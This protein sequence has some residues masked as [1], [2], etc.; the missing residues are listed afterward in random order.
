M[1]SLLVSLFL[2][3]VLPGPVEGASPPAADQAAIQRAAVELGDRSFAVRQRASQFLWRQGREAESALQQVARNGTGEAR[4]R[5]EQLLRD[6]R[7]GVVPAVPSHVIDLIRTYSYGRPAERQLAF[8][9]LL[10]NDH[11]VQVESLIRQEADPEV[12]QA[13][14]VRLCEAQSSA[15]RLAEVGDLTDLVDRVAGDQD[16]AWRRLTIARLLSTTTMIEQL[17]ERDQLAVLGDLVSRER[18]ADL[19]QQMLMNVFQNSGAVAA[20]IAKDEFDFLLSL[21]AAEPDEAA[22]DALLIQ[23]LTPANVATEVVQRGKLDVVL[24]FLRA[25][26]SSTARSQI[27]QQMLSTT[28]VVS[29]I[30]EDAGL[31]GVVALARD[32]QDPTTRGELLGRL[33][34][35]MQVRTHLTR[36]GQWKR[37]IQVAADEP[38]PAARHAYLD[39]LLRY[40]VFYSLKPDDGLR[41]LWLVVRNDED[42]AWR[43]V[44]AARLLASHQVEH[45]L[46]DE[47][48]IQWLLSQLRDDGAP[49][50]RSQLLDAAIRT[51][52]LQRMLL[53]RGLFAELFALARREPETT[54]VDLVMRLLST[55]N[56]AEQLKASNEVDLMLDMVDE[57][58][59]PSARREYLAGLFRNHWAMEAL[60][61]NGHYERLF[62]LARQETNEVDRAILFAEFLRTNPV[63][64]QIEERDQ[65]DT[66]IQYAEVQTD[67]NARHEYLKRLFTNTH[68]LT[69]L[70]DKDK[71]DALHR[72][73][74]TEADPQRRSELLASFFSMPN[75]LQ[76]MIDRKRADEVLEFAAGI[77]DEN[78][79]RQFLQ[80]LL[81]NRKAVEA[82]VAE[83]KFGALLELARS[84]PH[85]SYRASQIG[86][87]LRAP[88]V[89]EHLANGGNLGQL[90]EVVR[91]E[92]HENSRQQ[93]FSALIGR[94]E[95]LQALADGGFIDEMFEFVLGSRGDRQVRL[96][97]QIISAE[98]VLE[99]LAN[100]NRLQLLLTLVDELPPHGEQRDY[101]QLLFSNTRAMQALLEGGFFDDVLNI[102][103][104]EENPHLRSHM[105]GRLL[106]LDL[107]VRELCRRGR[108]GM[109]IDYLEVEQNQ[110][111]RV[112]FMQ[113]AFAS[114]PLTAALERFGRFDDLIDL[115]LDAIAASEADPQALAYRLLTSPRAARRLAARQQIDATLDPIFQTSDPIALRNTLQGLLTSHTTVNLLLADGRDERFREAIEDR[116]PASE[117][118]ALVQGSLTAQSRAEWLALAGKA[119]WVSDAISGEIDESRRG[120]YLQ[121]VCGSPAL[122][123]CMFEAGQFDFLLKQA[124]RASHDS[125]RESQV[126]G[127]VF[128]PHALRYF[129]D[130]GLLARVVKYVE[131]QAG[132]D[133]RRRGMQSVLY[134]PAGRDLLTIPEIAGHVLR[135][136]EREREPLRNTYLNIVLSHADVRQALVASGNFELLQRLALLHPSDEARR[137]HLRQALFAPSGQISYLVQRGD[138]EAAQQLLEDHASD[139]WGR[140]RLA[141]W[142]TVRGGLDEHI[143]QLEQQQ[144]SEP[145][146][147]DDRLLV[148]LWR[149]K[150]NLAAASRVAETLDDAGL[151]QALLVE[152]ARWDEASRLFASRASPLPVPLSG[153]APVA[154]QEI[155]RRGLL[156]AYQR[157]AGHTAD[158]DASLEEV[159]KLSAAAAA[160]LRWECAESLLLN[161]RFEDA[162]E[163]LRD[164]HPWIVFDMLVTDHRFEEAFELA[165]LAPA[166]SIDETWFATLPASGADSEAL[167]RARFDAALRIAAA[168]VTTG[169]RDR[170]GEVFALLERIATATNL[171][172][173]SRSPQ[174]TASVQL[175][176]KLAGGWARAGRR[177]QALVVAEKALV[178]TVNADYAFGLLFAELYPLRQQEARAVL[179][180]VQSQWGGQR[181]SAWLEPL[182]LLMIP[183]PPVEEHAVEAFL[184]IVSER[185]SR[186]A[187]LDDSAFFF[188]LGEACSRLGDDALAESCWRR[189][190]DELPDA[191]FA[192]ADLLRRQTRWTEAAERYNAIWQDDHEQLVALYLSGDALQNA[193]DLSEAARRKELASVSALVSRSRHDLAAGLERRGLDEDAGRQWR[194]LLRVAEPGGWDWNDA[195]RRLAIATGA[196]DPAAAARLW[197]QYALGNFRTTYQFTNASSYRT[198]PV[199]IHR[200][201]ARAA[202]EAGDFTSAEMSLEAALAANEGDTNLAE[203]FTPL[204]ASA[205][206]HAAADAVFDQIYQ[207]YAEGC[208]RFPQ[209]ALFHNNLAWVAARCHRR[210]DEARRHAVRAVE[211]EPDAASYIDTLAEVLFQQGDRATAIRLSKQSVQ[212]APHDATLRQQLD[213]F[214][215]ATLPADPA[216]A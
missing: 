115:C 83:G 39:L 63:V 161:E 119:E 95:V 7:F 41:E 214:Q 202:I 15:T 33:V 140:L 99:R 118:V 82:L 171:D 21:V 154:D 138:V 73:T 48:D 130:H 133:L 64:A 54:R 68:A 151:R 213:R 176:C 113:A 168:L 123:T 121:A 10:A 89:I 167:N 34:V 211:I 203:E 150:G 36:A 86:N 114:E 128:T 185:I 52:R 184:A 180:V 67:A 109:A 111:A 188:G 198:V 50:V 51:Y 78:A 193:G 40:G 38:H 147:T 80:R 37:A 195:A 112:E 136:I 170:A 26:A 46:Q 143:S 146:Q 77:A 62:A 16:E 74:Q 187:S 22:R 5:A 31:D 58:Q 137:L 177:D 108:I 194:L 42:A 49:E 212:L 84:E 93:M 100:E 35:S 44:A 174:R 13:L 71:F 96:I 47:V 131:A 24:E 25:R 14:L 102:A 101:L 201:Q 60:I 216:G 88:A 76:G 85:P 59:I 91:S 107:S 163:I 209:A 32:E 72:L 208:R 120:N 53:E 87:L 196:D 199:T 166:S 106:G 165:G 207:H 175:M 105:L 158:C 197:T 65:L 190:A 210:L 6:L 12:R 173:A 1:S 124:E 149:A 57:Y 8:A 155:E 81:Y 45:F 117:R 125:R 200:L 30:L 169:Q 66:L 160:D 141:T 3:A 56:A 183:S 27:L 4:Q 98:P 94:A 20:L 43:A 29:A 90:L 192:L 178:P 156:A 116:L 162:F 70:I 157:L 134:S 172:P 182:D 139:D 179:Q 92:E 135:W 97:G 164:S 75:V 19:R 11:H 215:T 18:S 110:A 205:G 181:P 191:A 9:E 145:D 61:G 79:R 2:S 206:R 148:Y 17:A 159:R 126:A 104:T 127:L 103:V 55:S 152:Q 153:T 132:D 186:D 189:A 129:A 144:Q 69:R 122:L 28:N 142:L 23:L 204:L